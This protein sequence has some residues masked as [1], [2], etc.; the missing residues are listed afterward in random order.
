MGDKLVS[1][2]GLSSSAI[3][4]PPTINA[5]TELA[6]ARFALISYLNAENRLSEE[7]KALALQ[8]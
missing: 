6:N 1:I 3:Q 4:I 7:E 2:G 5:E 8:G